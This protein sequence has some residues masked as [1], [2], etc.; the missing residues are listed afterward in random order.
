MKKDLL[1]EVDGLEIASDEEEIYS[2]N[3]EILED[4]EMLIGDTIEV[5]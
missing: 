5:R 1:L 3:A 2:D 4:E